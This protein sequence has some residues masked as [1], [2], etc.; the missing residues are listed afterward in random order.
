MQ[1]IKLFEYFN[2]EKLY[3]ITN[4]E[5]EK[6]HERQSITK[7]DLDMVNDIINTVA[8]NIYRATRV[9][10]NENDNI[11][12]F[13]DKSYPDFSYISIEG[14]TRR[15][16]IINLYKY[17]DEYWTARVTDHRNK[18]TSIDYLIDTKEGIAQLL[19]DI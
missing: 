3:H 19:H 9:H 2:T 11:P 5:W 4:S 8:P 17:V 6:S 12:F 15:T 1:Y 18:V 7:S 14:V 16:V 10:F 13:M